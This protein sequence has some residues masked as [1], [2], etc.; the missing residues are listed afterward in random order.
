MARKANKGKT[1][2]GLKL[3]IVNSNA[4]G[5]DIA[6]GEMQVC[7]PENRDGENT[8]CFG[9]FICGYEKIAS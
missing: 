3:K 2:D 4:A 7:V 5:I 9:S 1:K 8:R 6:Y